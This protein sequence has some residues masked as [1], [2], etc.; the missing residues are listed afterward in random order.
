[1]ESLPS[2]CIIIISKKLFY[3]DILTLSQVNKYFNLLF[4]NSE[5]VE[6]IMGKTIRSPLLNAILGEEIANKRK[7]R[8]GTIPLILNPRDPLATQYAEIPYYRTILGDVMKMILRIIPNLRHFRIIIS[9]S[10]RKAVS[11][12]QV[13]PQIYGDRI[14]NIKL[15]TITD[16]VL[17]IYSEKLE[18][19]TLI[20]VLK[21]IIKQSRIRGHTNI[22]PEKIE[23][24]T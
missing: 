23:A 16:I 15:C 20:A 1:M 2:D 13:Q 14:I 4:S 3:Q 5:I 9:V 24:W 18:T 7:N 12:Y 10:Y 22:I 17:T 19:S 11:Y 8:V 6:R 21:E